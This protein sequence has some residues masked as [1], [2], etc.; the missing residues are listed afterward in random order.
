MRRTQ[1]PERPRLRI[2]QK[3]VPNQKP[4]RICMP[5]QG[6]MTPVQRART[7]KIP[8]HTKLKRKVILQD[9]QRQGV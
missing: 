3:L 6:K 2:Q 1:K 4:V 9:L 8:T 7:T 5:T